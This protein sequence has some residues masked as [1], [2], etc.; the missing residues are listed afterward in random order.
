M[1]SISP[2]RCAGSLRL[3]PTCARDIAKV[4]GDEMENWGGHEI[5]LYP[6][7]TKITDKETKEKRLST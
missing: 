6:V 1:S 3:S 7:K 4:Y 2:T 5:E